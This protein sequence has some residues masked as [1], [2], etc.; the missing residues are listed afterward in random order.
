MKARRT[1]WALAILAW[2]AWMVGQWARDATLLTGFCFYIP[3]PILAGGWL[4]AALDGFRKHRW[5]TGALAGVLGIVPLLAVLSIENRWTRQN[6]RQNAEQA[7]G[8]DERP[9]RFVHWNVLR[10]R[11]G[12]DAVTGEL[13][14]RSA[15]FYL[16]S[17]IPRDLK[18]TDLAARFGEGRSVLV[19]SDMAVVAHGTLVEEPV[20]ES[21]RPLRAHIVRWRR[22]GLDVTILAVDLDSNPLIHRD[23]PLQEI[24]RLIRLHRPDII[25]GDFNAPRRSRALD[26]LPEG[27]VHAYEAAGCGWSYTWPVPLPVYAIDQCIAGPRLRPIR[28]E[29]DSTI[30]SDHRLQAFDFRFVEPAGR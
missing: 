14:G 2:C 28:Y 27:Y 26:P 16:L 24:V 9:L 11:L 29:L 23:P 13:I 21:R 7:A 15:D 17:E 22:D 4:I 10:G 1:I 30:R 19:L 18:P 25:A 5:R 8:N 20:I 6:T 12:W 3:S